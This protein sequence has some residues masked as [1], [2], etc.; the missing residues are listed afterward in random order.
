[1]NGQNASGLVVSK[2]RGKA[3]VEYQ[4]PGKSVLVTGSS[5]GMGTT[6]L[7]A[8]A[9]AGATCIV[10]YVADSAGQNRRDAERTAKRLRSLGIPV[11]LL[12]ADVQRYESVEMLMKRIVQLA[13]GLDILVSNAGILR[14][15]TIKKM[16]PEEWLSVL[17]TNLDGVFHCSKLGAEILR[18]GGRIVNIASIAGMVGFPGQA[19]HAA[20]KGGCPR[21]D[22]RAGAGASPAADHGQWRGPR[23]DRKPHTRKPAAGGPG[24]VRQA[25]PR[26]AALQARGRGPCRAVP[27]V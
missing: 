13:G 23:R 11:H 2:V 3:M 27:G 22:R 10:N 17:D 7:E 19:N 1:M 26:R 8:F 16:T 24:G 12:E 25:D 18:D 14:G 4:F 5:R 20:A 21:P 6:L 9:R 15:R